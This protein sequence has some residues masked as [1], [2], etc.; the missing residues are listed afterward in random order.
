MRLRPSSRLRAGARTPI[1]RGHRSR[2]QAVVE[3]AI[4]VPV[5][6]LLLLIAL[7]FGRLFFSY[8]S[9]SNAARE[10]A[11]YAAGQPNDCGG[12][13]CLATSGIA[14][15]ASQETSSQNRG[16]GATAI[17]NARSLRELGRQP[18]LL[19]ERDNWRWRNREHR[20]RAGEPA[21]PVLHAVDQRFLWQQPEPQRVSVGCRERVRNWRWRSDLLRGRARC[22]S[23]TL[24]WW[25][26]RA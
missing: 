3:F 18:D 11:A 14:K 17:S 26:P 16:G 19:R 25:S 15:H 7:D 9:I 6:F 13:P 20:D 1:G 5:M 2:G 8:V 22:L 21:L 23:R 12:N 10:G 24:L 4:V